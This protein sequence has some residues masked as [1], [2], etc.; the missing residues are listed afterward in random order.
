MEYGNNYWIGVRYNRSNPPPQMWPRCVF[1]IISRFGLIITWCNLIISYYYND[2]YYYYYTIGVV[3]IFIIGAG[4]RFTHISIVVFF[5]L[6]NS[7]KCIVVF[8]NRLFVFLEERFNNW[9]TDL[10]CIY[11][12]LCVHTYIHIQSRQERLS[13]LPLVSDR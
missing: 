10:C 3:F 8:V 5:G 2:Y 12:C 7:W 4:C 6:S 1:S 11:V 9:N 13:V